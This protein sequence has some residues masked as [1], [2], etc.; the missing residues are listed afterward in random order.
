MGLFRRCHG[1]GRL[2]YEPSFSGAEGLSGG[3]H[4]HVGRARRPWLISPDGKS[5][6]IF[7]TLGVVPIYPPA[8][9]EMEHIL[10]GS[11][12]LESNA[13]RSA[14][15]IHINANGKI[16]VG[17]HAFD[18]AGRHHIRAITQMAHE[19]G[20]DIHDGGV[21]YKRPVERRSRFATLP[22][23]ASN[24]WG[25]VNRRIT[26]DADTDECI[27]NEIARGV[28]KTNLYRMLFEGVG[29][30]TTIFLSQTCRKTV[31]AELVAVSVDPEDRDLTAAVH[32][33]RSNICCNSE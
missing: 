17:I 23:H 31:K 2:W 11:F 25:E 20:A 32:V 7:D 5:I 4:I 8:I 12:K 9:E 28:D 21:V 6:I 1:H 18:T 26:Y 13:F 19:A 3:F 14:T 29:N 15:G 30:I 33:E 27:P 22:S 24:R 16:E 10:L